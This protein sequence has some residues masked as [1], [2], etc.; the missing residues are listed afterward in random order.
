M[1]GCEDY[2]LIMQ[3]L[4]HRPWIYDLQLYFNQNQNRSVS[5]SI[6]KTLVKLYTFTL[7]THKYI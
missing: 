2:I 6:Y 5:F 3:A 4:R 1:E 7:I